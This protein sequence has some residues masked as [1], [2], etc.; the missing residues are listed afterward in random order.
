MTIE[1]AVPSLTLTLDPGT[2]ALAPGTIMQDL[3]GEQVAVDAEVVAADL[4]GV[5]AGLAEALDLR[6]R[7]WGRGRPLLLPLLLLLRLVPPLHINGDLALVLLRGAG[8]GGGG[9]VMGQ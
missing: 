8:T 2:A 9:G 6:E 7:G 3:V 4:A 1:I 5:P